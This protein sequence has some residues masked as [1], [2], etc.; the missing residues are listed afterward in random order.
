MDYYEG[1]TL[2]EVMA[3][4]EL[5]SE[6]FDFGQG[7]MKIESLLGSEDAYYEMAIQNRLSRNRNSED[8]CDFQVDSE[9]SSKENNCNKNN[10]RCRKAKEKRHLKY[11]HEV[12][13]LA[14]REKDGY[15]TR[16]YRRPRVAR[17][18]KRLSNKKVRQ[19]E[20]IPNGGS[21]K[22]IYDYKSNVI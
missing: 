13:C 5:E 2:Q 21:Y 7:D 17:I 9:D 19:F 10:I 4:R 12:N 3:F 18:Y 16:R 22:K 20:N 14:T 1:C 6:V 8:N 15:Y 11:L